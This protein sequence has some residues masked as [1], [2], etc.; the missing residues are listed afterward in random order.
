MT[1]PDQPVTVTG[2]LS[3]AVTLSGD[4]PAIHYGHQTITLFFEVYLEP[5]GR[6]GGRQQI[7]TSGG[8]APVWSLQ[9]GELFY[10][11][12]SGAMMA[13]P[14]ETTPALA[15][16]IPTLLFEG[17]YF[18]ETGRVYAERHYDVDPSGDRF[19]MVTSAADQRR[20]QLGG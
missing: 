9:G 18:L 3:R 8:T 2:L 15:L 17:Q 6:E 1:L 20:A 4:A 11:D 19:L 10:R 14:I 13:V 7:S 5:L 16:G 12:S